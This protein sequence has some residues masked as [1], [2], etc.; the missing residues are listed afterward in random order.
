M[1][2]IPTILVLAGGPDPEHDVSLESARCI[3]EAINLGDRFVALTHEFQTIDASALAALP[4]DI[5]FP[6]LH[7]R[8]GEGGPIQRLLEADGRPFVG[9]GSDT[10][11]IAIDKIETKRIAS[12]LS[13]S[14]GA[15]RVKVSES[16]SVDPS[17]SAP[18]LEFPF[19]VKPQ[20]EG[21]AIG[22]FI[23][24]DESDWRR[25]HAETIASARETMAEPYIDGREVTIGMIDQGAGLDVLPIIEI[26]PMSGLYDYNA[27]YERDDTKYTKYPDIPSQL[28]IDL[29]AFCGALANRLGVRDIARADFMLDTDGFAHLLEINTMP[30]FT[31]HSLVPMACGGLGMTGLCELLVDRAISRSTLTNQPN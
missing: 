4:G 22:L 27:K 23:C 20:F 18:P 14:I 7:G 25:A 9:S 28:T 30:G 11:R 10:S 3:A 8:F 12:C 31:S 29:N 24:R 26:T 17:N 2:N 21:S 1:T 19:V 6:A 13:P 15:T 16:V 5:V